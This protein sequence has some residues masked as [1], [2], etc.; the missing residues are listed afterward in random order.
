MAYI[1]KYPEINTLIVLSLLGKN[2]LNYQPRY[3]ISLGK[4]KNEKKTYI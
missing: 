4:K 3:I 1:V 2:K